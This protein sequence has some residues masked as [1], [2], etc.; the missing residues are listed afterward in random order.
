MA[1][2][3]KAKRERSDSTRPSLD[4]VFKQNQKRRKCSK[5][6]VEHFVALSQAELNSTDLFQLENVQ[7]DAK[8]CWLIA[9]HHGN[10]P[11]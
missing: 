11:M 3:K 4:E 5:D 6:L 10:V 1:S 9:N 8:V 7:E 2:I